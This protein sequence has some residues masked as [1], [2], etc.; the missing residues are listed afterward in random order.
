MAD[1]RTYYWRFF[2]IAGRFVGT[3]F[4][5]VG[6][7]LLYYAISHRDVL[8]IVLVSVCV[9]LGVLMLIA[10]PYRP[11]LRESDSP[12]SADDHTEKE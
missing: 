10:K 11:D 1:W 12:K 8:A 9:V 5:V 3:W 2:N 7:I 4:V 6:G